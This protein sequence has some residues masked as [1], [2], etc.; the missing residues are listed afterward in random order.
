MRHLHTP[1]HHL[2]LKVQCSLDELLDSFKTQFSKDK[3]CIG[4]TNLTEIQI[5]TGTSNP[6]SQKPYHT[7]MKHHDWG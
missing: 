6:V 2:P 3:M 4:M 7:V 1:L 5:D